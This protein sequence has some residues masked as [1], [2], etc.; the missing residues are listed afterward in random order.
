[1][2]NIALMLLVTMLLVSCYKEDALTPSK[3]T[4][5]IFSIPQGDHDYDDVVVDWFERYGFYTL[6]VFEPKDLY[7]YNDGWLEGGN[8]INIPT[9]TEKGSPGNEEFVGYAMDIFHDMMMRHYPDELLKQGMPLR[10]FI[11]SEL[12]NLEY[13]RVNSEYVPIKIWLYEGWDNIAVNGASSYITDS[14]TWQD[15][16]DCSK[17]FN[18]YFLER[19]ADKGLIPM[20]GE[21]FFAVSVYEDESYYGVE[22]F[23][24]GFLSGSINS[25]NSDIYKREDFLAYCCLAGYPLEVLNGEAVSEDDFDDGYNPPLEGLFSRPESAPCKR[26]YEILVK[27]LKSLGIDMDKIQY[28]DK[29]SY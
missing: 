15:Q 7:W 17:E 20:P 2:R 24:N 29:V 18:A 13:D 11:C 28:P 19:L 14:L 22:V 26:K 21:D 8:P 9:G 5:E 3:G 16:L 1:M 12:L 27:H 10:V 23:E 6:Y 4:E 25:S